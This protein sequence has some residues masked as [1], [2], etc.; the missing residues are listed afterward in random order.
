MNRYAAIFEC[1][2][3]RLTDHV[4]GNTCSLVSFDKIFFCEAVNHK[5][6]IHTKDSVLECYIKLR[7]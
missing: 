5:M 1:W 6:V 4:S 2:Q 7:N 3:A